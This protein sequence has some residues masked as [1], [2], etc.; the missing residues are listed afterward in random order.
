MR[1]TP[2][3]DVLVLEATNIVL[4]SVDFSHYVNPRRLP[5][6]ILNSS[7]P[8]PASIY[9]VITCR[10]RRPRLISFAIEWYTEQILYNIKRRRTFLHDSRSKFKFIFPNRL[11]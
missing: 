11:Q 10:L 3:D 4:V 7:G 2:R 9:F 1:D 8:N 5:E 6:M